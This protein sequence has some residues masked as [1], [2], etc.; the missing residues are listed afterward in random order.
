VLNYAPIAAALLLV[1]PLLIGRA[2]LAW[3][4]TPA[5][6][7]GPTADPIQHIV[8][9]LRENH[10]YDNLFGCFPGGELGDYQSAHA[11]LASAWPHRSC[12]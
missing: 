10:T 5:G 4:E 11:V 2:G 3:A 6:S 9:F 1:A 8:I 7:P 12:T